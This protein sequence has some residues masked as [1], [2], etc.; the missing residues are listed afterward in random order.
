MSSQYLGDIMLSKLGT[1]SLNL[2]GTIGTQ[3]INNDIQIE[4]IE[5]AEKLTFPIVSV[6]D[7]GENLENIGN[8]ITT[9]VNDLSKTIYFFL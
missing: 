7:S 1:Y 3:S 5:D 6:E 8:R 4:D 2:K 9:I